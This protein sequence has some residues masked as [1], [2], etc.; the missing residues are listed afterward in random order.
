VLKRII[1]EKALAKNYK[2]KK[3]IVKPK[4]KKLK[5]TLRS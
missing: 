2:I 1:D 4:I 3:N 5:K